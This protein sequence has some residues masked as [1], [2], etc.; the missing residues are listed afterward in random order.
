MCPKSSQLAA[1]MSLIFCVDWGKLGMDMDGFE[2]TFNLLLLVAL[3][4]N[5]KSKK[6]YLSIF[7]SNK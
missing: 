2:S 3:S 1:A 5:V 7:R 4:N 6:Y